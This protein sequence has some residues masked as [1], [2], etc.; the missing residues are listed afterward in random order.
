MVKVQRRIGNRVAQ[1]DIVSNVEHVESVS[2]SS[3]DLSVAKII[4]PFVVV[5]TQ[6]CDLSQDFT[7]RHGR[8]AKDSHDKYI[9]SAIVAPLYNVEHFFQGEHLSR[10]G[11]RMQQINRKRTPGKT[12]LQ[13]DN[14][15]YHYMD[16]PEDVPIPPSVVD[17]KHY[18]TVNVEYL[19]QQRRKEFVCRVSPLYRELLTQRFANF[20]ARIG[21][22][23]QL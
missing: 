19:R 23:D 20:L 15:R 10:L 7:F 16:F 21:L 5:L 12:I 9:F 18:F 6:D 14:P 17:F 2:E 11:Y 3:G 8:P 22:P 1:G 4:F 13:N